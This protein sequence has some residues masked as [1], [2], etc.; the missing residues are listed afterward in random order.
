V[1]KLSKKQ[2]VTAITEAVRLRFLPPAR[3]FVVNPP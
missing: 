3:Y 1:L 2:H